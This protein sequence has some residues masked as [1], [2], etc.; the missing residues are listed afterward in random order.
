MAQIELVNVRGN[1]VLPNLPLN[2]AMTQ[3]DI[4]HVKPSSG[5]DSNT[6]KRPD[7]ALKT[8]AKAQALA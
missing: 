8:L 4:W 7:V 1:R 3:G 2:L 6:G 5:S